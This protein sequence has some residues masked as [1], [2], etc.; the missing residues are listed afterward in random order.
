MKFFFTLFCFFI[1]TGVFSQDKTIEWLNKHTI[2]VKIPDSAENKDVDDYKEFQKLIPILKD[3]KI[4]L[5]GE[6]DHV[7]ASTFEA[8]VRLIKFLHKYLGFNVL[9]FETDLYTTG[10]AYR[11]FS[12]SQDSRELKNSLYAFWGSVKSTEPLFEYIK[13][14][15]STSSPLKFIG[16]D[17]QIIPRY[18]FADSIDAFLKRKGSHILKYEY[19]NRF[20][21]ILKRSYRNPYL[22]TNKERLLLLNIID[23]ILFE[24][25]INTSKIENDMLLL[26]G[27]YNLKGHFL[28]VWLDMPTMYNA[29][30]APPP[31]DSL[32]GFVGDRSSLGPLNRRDK[33]MADN[34][35]WL[36]DV[37]Y[38]NEKIIVWGA[39]AHTMYNYHQLEFDGYITTEAFP[40][41]S[42]FKYAAYF[43]N[44]GTHLKKAYGNNIYNLGFTHLGG[45]V[46]YNRSGNTG[47]I[48][49][50]SISPDSIE[51]WL[52]KSKYKTGIIDFSKATAL[53][54]LFTEK[55]TS[56]ILG[57]SQAKGK[58]VNFFDG[59]FFIEKMH[60]LEFVK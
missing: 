41:H 27:L 42:R 18:A 47:Q 16:F 1:W 29:I 11:R 43:L 30:G 12:I 34:L 5:L 49:T 45:T 35:V 14:S 25:N 19:Y 40:F 15:Q 31:A 9:A 38:K 56:N 17:N 57:E 8:K 21:E 32:Y 7:Y 33:D 13:S 44:M 3:K 10:N 26:R 2:P 51:S 36:K 48:G 39:T 50:L 54:I 24:S 52:V 37:L 58:L 6:E 53:P 59:L 4:V 55:Y 23:D 46:N 60:P 22:L 20:T 28:N